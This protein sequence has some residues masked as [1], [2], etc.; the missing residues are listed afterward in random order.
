[1]GE[2]SG[3]Q[4]VSCVRASTHAA[5]LKYHHVVV[6]DGAELRRPVGVASDHLI[7]Q[8]LEVEGELLHTDTLHGGGG[9]STVNTNTLL[10]TMLECVCQWVCACSTPVRC[11]ACPLVAAFAPSGPRQ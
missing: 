11:E 2:I 4:N 8:V 3:F 1:M 10:V 9:G 7:D 5:D 6:T